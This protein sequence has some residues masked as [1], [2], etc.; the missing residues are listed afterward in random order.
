MSADRFVT[1]EAEGFVFDTKE[2]QQEEPK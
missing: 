2:K 1:D